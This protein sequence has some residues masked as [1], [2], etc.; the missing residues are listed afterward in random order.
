MTFASGKQIDSYEIV[1]PDRR[2]QHGGVYCAHDTKLKRGMT[3]K[4]LPDAFAR[5]PGRMARFQR[6]AEIRWLAHYDVAL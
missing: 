3:L 4:V 6:E 5:G 1:R 2:G